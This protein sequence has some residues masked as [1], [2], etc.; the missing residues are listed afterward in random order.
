MSHLSTR[1]SH[2][3]PAEHTHRTQPSTGTGPNRGHAPSEHT[4]EREC[5]RE[6]TSAHVCTRVNTSAHVRTRVHTCAHLWPLFQHTC[7]YVCSNTHQDPIIPTRTD[8]PT[9]PLTHTHPI[10]PLPVRSS[11]PSPCPVPPHSPRSATPSLLRPS[12]PPILAS[13]LGDSSPSPPPSCPAP[14]AHDSPCIFKRF[15]TKTVHNHGNPYL[16]GPTSR[17]PRCG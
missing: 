9:R 14:P 13:P 7:A 8:L 1:T 2:Q 4:C 15:S 16:T 17:V 3:D 12:P 10:R 6:N 11:L 5:T